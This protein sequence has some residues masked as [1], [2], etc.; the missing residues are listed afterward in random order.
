MPS[1]TR[2]ATIN[3]R[4]RPTPSALTAVHRPVSN[5]IAPVTSSCAT[6]CCHNAWLLITHVLVPNAY[7][8]VSRIAL[9]VVVRRRSARY[10]SEGRQRRH[11]RRRKLL[12]DP[13]REVDAL[14]GPAT[15]RHVG[16][17]GKI[18]RR[19]ERRHDDGIQ[20]AD[21]SARVGHDP[22]GG[23]GGPF[24][25]IR[26]RF[27]ALRH[28]RFDR[29][30]QV[31]PVLPERERLIARGICVSGR[32]RPAVRVVDDETAE[33]DDE[34]HF[35]IAPRE[36][37]RCDGRARGDGCR[38]V[39]PLRRN[40]RNWRRR[41]RR[42]GGWI[43]PGRERIGMR[44]IEGIRWFGA[45]A[46]FRGQQRG[47]VVLPADPPGHVRAV[48]AHVPA[49]AALTRRGGAGPVEC[50]GIVD[51]HCRD[52]RMLAG[53]DARPL[54]LVPAQ[55]PG[56]FRIEAAEV[57]IPERHVP[58][59]HASVDARERTFVEVPVRGVAAGILQQ[60]MREHRRM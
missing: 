13:R 25:P 35:Q 9:D 41:H 37:C 30:E 12:H 8:M 15:H 7:A 29:I 54:A 5:R 57:E 42:R 46:A 17:G 21:V 27:S 1:G 40:P 19:D 11:E 16:D 36:R 49:V 51:A 32:D 34:G 14:I 55:Q 50:G 6:P 52:H 59:E 53:H 31:R 24:Q 38:I 4:S 43:Q 60:M 48:R 58:R 45:F 20:R 56:R 33:A 18:E 22:V 23:A 26:R 10:R 44:A 2:F 28:E 39:R 3:P 47:V